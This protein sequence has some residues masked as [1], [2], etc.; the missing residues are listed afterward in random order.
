MI[1]GRTADP[2]QQPSDRQQQPSTG[3][4]SAPPNAN[5]PS[6]IDPEGKRLYTFV[7][8][9]VSPD[10]YFLYVMSA[11]D[12][13][14]SAHRPADQRDMSALISYAH[15]ACQLMENAN[16]TVADPVIDVGRQVQRD[17]PGM[18]LLRLCSPASL[19]RPTVS[20]SSGTA[21]ERGTFSISSADSS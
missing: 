16:D 10:C 14:F 2:E 5:C 20:Q 3:Q 7:T 21:A 13:G 19:Q 17:N 18:S 15:N 9:D 11:Q 6:I 12:S 8:P 4:S 1:F